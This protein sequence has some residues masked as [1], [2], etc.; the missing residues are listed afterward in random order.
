MPHTTHKFQEYIDTPSSDDKSVC[1][2]IYIYIYNTHIYIIHT[3]THTHSFFPILTFLHAIV[4]RSNDIVTFS[5]K[6][7]DL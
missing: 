5:I 1:V 6:L 4:T 7:L 2:S 3:H